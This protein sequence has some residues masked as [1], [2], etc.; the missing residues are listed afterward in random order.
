MVLDTLCSPPFE[1]MSGSELRWLSA[2]TVFLLAI[3]SAKRVSELHALSVSESCLRWNSDGSGV[4]LWPNAAFLPKVLTCSYLNQ[5]VRLAQFDP[6]SGEERS[7]LLCPVRALR[8]YVEATTG[9]QSSF[10]SAMAG[11]GGVL[12]F[13]NS[14]TGLWRPLPVHTEQRAV[15]CHPARR[16]ILPG[17]FPHH[18][19]P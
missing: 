19:Q 11:L 17:V 7:K 1:P 12:P 18:E 8:T 14:A 3:T 2:K 10:S 4:T 9:S 16:A 15:P 13:Q 6:P 5:P